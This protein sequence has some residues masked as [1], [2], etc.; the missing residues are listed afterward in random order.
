MHAVARGPL[1]AA[2]VENPPPH[3]ASTELKH[4]VALTNRVYTLRRQVSY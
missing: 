1:V 3:V 2:A 4:V